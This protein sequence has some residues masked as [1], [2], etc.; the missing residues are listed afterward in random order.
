MNILLIVGALLALYF[1]SRKAEA[2]TPELTP[3]KTMLP[4]LTDDGAKVI[5]DGGV[6][7]EPYFWWTGN[8]WVPREQ[9][10]DWLAKEHGYV[11]VKGLT[12]P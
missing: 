2:V 1:V 10:P 9:I 6:V 12:K 4:P 8:G 3:E 7:E 11:L 5:P